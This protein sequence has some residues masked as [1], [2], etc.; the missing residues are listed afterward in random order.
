MS[1]C[2]LSPRKAAVHA[3][4]G[5]TESGS[6]PTVAD[7]E[8][9]ACTGLFADIRDYMSANVS[10]RYRRMSPLDPQPTFDSVDIQGRKPL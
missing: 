10:L 4:P 1:D 9:A 8:R 6:K 5:M 2:P 3:V 7:Q